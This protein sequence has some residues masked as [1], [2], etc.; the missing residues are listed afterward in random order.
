MAQKL[1]KTLESLRK[2]D[3]WPFLIFFYGS[4]SIFIDQTRQMDG[5]LLLGNGMVHFHLEVKNNTTYRV[6]L[7]FYKWEWND[8]F[9]KTY[10]ACLKHYSMLIIFILP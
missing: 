5:Q 7:L 2:K 4:F 10:I 8:R 1:E 9:P 3:F 6:N